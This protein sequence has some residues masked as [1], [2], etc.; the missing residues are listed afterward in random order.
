[1]TQLPDFS[2]YGYQLKLELGRNVAGGRVTYLAKKI[3]PQDSSASNSE[4]WVVIKQ[5]QF[6]TSTANWSDFKA[7]EREIQVLQSLNYPGIPK[8]LDSFETPTGFCMV[9][10]YKKANSLAMLRSFEPEQIKQIALELLEILVYLQSLTP[11]VIHRDF[12]PENIL[13]AE[14]PNGSLKVYLVDFGFA[15]LG[16]GAPHWPPVCRTPCGTWARFLWNIA[17]IRCRPPSPT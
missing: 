6:A 9:Q 2:E 5:F 17:P 7:H 1:M 14:N 3:S 13:V 11:L 4:D 10:E 12:K 15:Q 8:Y 16:G